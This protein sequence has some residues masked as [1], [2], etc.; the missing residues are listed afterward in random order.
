MDLKAERVLDAGFVLYR[1]FLNS[2][3][4]FFRARGD[5][6]VFMAYETEGP[7]PRRWMTREGTCGSGPSDACSMEPEE[8]ERLIMQFAT[9]YAI[10]G[11]GAQ[12]V[13]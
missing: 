1:G 8:A 6:W 7:I 11:T 2:S 9:E 5:K 3:R 4:F 10:G 13:G 12:K